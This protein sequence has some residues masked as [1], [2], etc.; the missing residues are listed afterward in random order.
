MYISKKNSY[1]IILEQCIFG[2][3]KSIYLTVIIRRIVK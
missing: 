3:E 1:Y 2:E